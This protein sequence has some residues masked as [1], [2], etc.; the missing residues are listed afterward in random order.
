MN[1]VYLYCVASSKQVKQ[2]EGG[3]IDKEYPIF[4]KN[5]K[6]VAAVL[7]LVNR[8]DFTGPAGESNLK[9][10]EWIGPR[11]YRHDVVVKEV[12]EL[13][14]VL[15]ARFGTIFSSQEALEIFL[16]SHGEEISRF[17]SFVADK[18]EW[19]VK[20]YI[21]KKKAIRKLVSMA[22]TQEAEQLNKLPAGTRYFKE[23]LLEDKARKE[24]KS[25]LKDVLNSMAAPLI[26]FASEYS[27]C[28]LLS[29]EATGKDLDMVLNRAFLVPRNSVKE[30]H[31]RVDQMNTAHLQ[32]GLILERSGPWP[33][34][35][36][37]PKLEINE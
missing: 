22:L 8:A 2:I 25:W 23:K 15:P 30:F 20:G 5:S 34:Y 28:K 32:N 13:S 29:R 11:A 36:F 9:S 31:R 27:E 24:L 17:L 1:F 7:S 3:G 10:I 35:N 12:M 14:P 4:V 26:S 19:S 33:P 21:D 18:E 6:D 37:C 16:E